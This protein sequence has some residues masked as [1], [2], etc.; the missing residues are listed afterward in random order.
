MDAPVFTQPSATDAG[1]QAVRE[2]MWAHWRKG[3]AAWSVAWR[4]W[5][6][7][8][9]LAWGPQDLNHQAREGCAVRIWRVGLGCG[10]SN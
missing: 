2:R 5:R 7:V 9:D 3:V 4:R 6:E 8:I 1:N 10:R